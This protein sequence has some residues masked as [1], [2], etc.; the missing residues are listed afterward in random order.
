LAGGCGSQSKNAINGKYVDAKSGLLTFDFHSGSCDFT[1]AGLTKECTY[2]VAGNKITL[3]R[4]DG[5]VEMTLTRN[6]DGSLVDN[7]SG[8]KL[9]RMTQ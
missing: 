3:R 1:F 2:E 9:I 7:G 5:G 4:A 6:S 8:N